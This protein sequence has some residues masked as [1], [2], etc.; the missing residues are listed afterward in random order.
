VSVGRR[1]FSSFETERCAA[2]CVTI[3]SIMRDLSPPRAQERNGAVKRFLVAT[4]F[5]FRAR[6]LVYEDR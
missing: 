1:R 2:H 6:S 5:P 3:L 4:N